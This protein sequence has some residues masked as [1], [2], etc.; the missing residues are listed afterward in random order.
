MPVAQ[1]KACRQQL[2]RTA[3]LSQYTTAYSVEDLEDVRRALGYQ[4]I[5]LVG[6]SYGTVTIRPAVDFA[7][8]EEVLTVLTPPQPESVTADGARR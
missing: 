7:R 6:G 2:E 8:L 3:D 1:V 5:N 4:R